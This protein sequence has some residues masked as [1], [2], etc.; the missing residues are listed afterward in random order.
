MLQ[1]GR[2]VVPLGEFAHDLADVDAGVHPFRA[3]RALVGLHDIAAEDD[4]RHAVAPGVV[5]RH[6]GVLQADDAVTRHGE[7]LALDLGIALRHVDG[8]V[9]VHAGDDFRLVVAAVIDDGFMQA[10]VARRAVDR[11]IFDVERLEHVDHEVAAAR[12]LIH[13]VLAGAMVSA[14]IW[15]GPGTAALNFSCGAA[16]IALAAT[17]GVTAAAAPTRP[18]PLRKLRRLESGEIA[19]FRHERPPRNGVKAERQSADSVVF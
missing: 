9:L 19:A 3:R 18:A 7:R 4:D 8:D 13:R 14:A 10:A 1:R 12:G 17:G 2:L 5:H 16:G 6:G 11:Q 15:R